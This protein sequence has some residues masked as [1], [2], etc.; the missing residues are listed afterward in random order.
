MAT[1]LDLAGVPLPDACEERSL[2]PMITSSE[3]S[4]RGVAVSGSAIDV[5]SVD[6]AA[7]TVQD[8][9]WCLIDRP[10]QARWELYDKRSD[11]AEEHNVIASYAGE[12]DRL[13]RAVLDFLTSHGAHP[14]L[15][16]WFESGEKGDTSDYVHRPP[17]LAN[18][19]PYFRLA[20][21]I[22]LHR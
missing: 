22:E 18:Y 16:R 5:A 19:K 17:Y 9:R 8:G 4:G 12:A 7:L 2:A 13:H 3:D 6:D 15:V 14:A 20:L 21:D 1:I 10:D 11:R